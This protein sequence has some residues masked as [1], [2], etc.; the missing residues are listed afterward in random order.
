MNISYCNCMKHGR[1]NKVILSLIFHIVSI[2][3]IQ[4]IHLLPLQHPLL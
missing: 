2:P 1:E 4:Q 3:G